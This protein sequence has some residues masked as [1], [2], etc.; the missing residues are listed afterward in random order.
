MNRKNIGFGRVGTL[1]L[2]FQFLAYVGYCSF[3][4]YPQNVMSQY[5]G[6]VQVTTLMNL[7]GSLVGYLINYF[8]LAPRIGT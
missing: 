8:F 4:N 7:I 1:V 3:T 5:Y 2:V 6:G